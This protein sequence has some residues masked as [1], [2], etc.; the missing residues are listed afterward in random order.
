M[1]SVQVIAVTHVRMYVH[2]DVRTQVHED[3]DCWTSC[4]YTISYTETVL[5]SSSRPVISLLS[6]F[7]SPLS[8]GKR[9]GGREGERGEN[10]KEGRQAGGGGRYRRRKGWTPPQ[11]H[12]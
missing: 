11:L 7:V 6:V 4:A 3:S 12:T 1:S 2:T 10:R 5:P 9:E 8:G